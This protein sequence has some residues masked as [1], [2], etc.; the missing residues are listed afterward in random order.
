MSGLP[1][2]QASIWAAHMAGVPDGSE[3]TE[4]DGLA[5]GAAAAAGGPGSGVQGLVQALC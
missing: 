5:G 3:V 2:A 4:P 1:N